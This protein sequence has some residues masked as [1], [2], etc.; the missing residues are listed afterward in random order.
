MNDQ[1]DFNFKSG[2]AVMAG[3][4]NAGKS[5][6]LNKFAGVDLSPVTHKPQ[7]TRQNILAICEGADYQ[8]VFVDTPGFLHAE[9]RLQQVMLNSLNQALGEDADVV[10]FVYDATAGLA[11]H[12]PL[13]KKLKGLYCP[14][15]VVINKVDL[16]ES[17]EELLKI[18]R[19]LLDELNVKELFLANAKA[20][21]GVKE[22]EEAVARHIPNSPPYFPQGQL[23]DRWER[24][25]IAEFIREQIFLLYSQEIPYAS[26]VEIETFTED[27]GDKNFIR[28]IIHVER[29]TQ[30]PIIIGK[31]GA[32]IAKLRTAAQARIQDFLQQKYRLELQVTVTPGWRGDSKALKKFGFIGQ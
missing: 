4:A 1:H 29:S 6:L 5:T 23:T 14:L 19:V 12:L 22:L 17:E 31:G 16:I 3:L 21:H 24:F 20:G 27:L 32:A 8:I 25:Y 18:Q 7:T 9:Y 30:K 10:I 11:K 2:F 15:L 26:F 28:A 13:I